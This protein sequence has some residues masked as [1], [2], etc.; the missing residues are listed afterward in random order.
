MSKNLKHVLSICVL[1]IA[2]TTGITLKVQAAEYRYT[3]QD[4]TA[5][6][7]PWSAK[8]ASGAKVNYCYV[9]VHPR[10]WGKPLQPIFPFGAYITPD[11]P[12][13]FSPL[14]VNWRTLQVK[15]TGDIN[16][17]RGLSRYWFDVYWGDSTNNQ[18]ARNFGK[19]KIS[20]KVRY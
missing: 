17:R 12:I 15:D 2:L 8:T 20:Y 16:N 11:S 7:A 3:N 6:T 19:K 14:G 5:Y 1:T 18:S 9:A 4:V 10:T 13:Y